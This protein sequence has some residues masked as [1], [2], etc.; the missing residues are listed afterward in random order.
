MRPRF[1]LRNASPGPGHR[2][3]TR[4]MRGQR[5]RGSG[6]EELRWRRVQTSP[7]PN[8]NP[9]PSWGSNSGSGSG[10]DLAPPML[11]GRSADR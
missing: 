9:N 6:S 2:A 7:I 4:D 10:W 8:L 11:P 3:L 1:S 5:L